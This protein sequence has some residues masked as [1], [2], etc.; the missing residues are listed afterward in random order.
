MKIN[1]QAQ[2]E[3]ER[4]DIMQMLVGTLAYDIMHRYQMYSRF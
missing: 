4:A 3:R 2:Y 1:E